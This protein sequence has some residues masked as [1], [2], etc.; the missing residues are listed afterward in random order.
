MRTQALR[1]GQGPNPTQGIYRG[2][3]GPLPQLS[4]QATTPGLVRG[5]H[6]ARESPFPL[7]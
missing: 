6:A 2:Q 5:L 1:E 7:E 3:W 4:L